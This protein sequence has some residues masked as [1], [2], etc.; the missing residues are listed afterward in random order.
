MVGRCGGVDPKIV[1]RRLARMRARATL[2]I[3]ACKAEF[4]TTEVL[5]AMDVFSISRM[6][7]LPALRPTTPLERLAMVRKDR[8]NSYAS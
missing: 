2:V 5:Q 3:A 4:N 7:S 8:D 1:D 6:G